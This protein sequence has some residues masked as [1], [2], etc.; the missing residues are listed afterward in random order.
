MIL[1]PYQCEALR[2]VERD[3]KT[4]KS[5]CIVQATGTGKTL[6]FCWYVAKVR[7]ERR[8]LI[9]V[10][11]S[12]LIS[13]T[14]ATLEA[15]GETPDIEQGER[16]V[17]PSLFGGSRIVVGTVQS[18][19]RPNR[20]SRFDPQEFGTVI[21]DECHR[22][23]PSNEQYRVI[24]EHFDRN[25]DVRHLGATATPM[26]GDG[27]ALSTWFE[28]ESYR[29]DLG[30]ATDEGWLVPFVQRYVVVSGI[31]W[32]SLKVV[33]GEYTEA[34]LENAMRDEQTHY[35]IAGAVRDQHEGRPTIAFVSGVHAAE[36]VA[37]ILRGELGISAESVNGSTPRDRRKLIYDGFDRGDV[38]VLVG[39]DVFCLDESTEILTSAGW[40]GIDEFTMNHQV[41]N[42]QDG[43]IWFSAVKGMVKRNR[44]PG[45]EIY[46]VEHSKRS[47][48]VTGKHRMLVRDSVK[49]RFEIQHAE[50]LAGRKVQVP[51]SGFAETFD[52]EP[53]PP[54]TLTARK[55]S[56]LIA[57]NAYNLRKS[58]MSYADAKAEAERR[59]SI[60]ES[61]IVKRPQELSLAEC[62]LI[63][64]FLAE[65]SKS[66]LASGGVEY[67]ISQAMC[68]PSIIEWFDAVVAE[69]GFDCARREYPLRSNHGVVLWSFCR[70]TG[71]GT[72][73][74]TGLFGIEPYLDK[75]GCQ[76]FWGLNGDQFAALIEGLHFGDGKHGK[77]NAVPKSFWITG[78]RKKLFDLLQGVACCRGYKASVRPV[79][80][81][82]NPNHSPQWNLGLTLCDAAWLYDNRLALESGWKPERVW[83]VTSESGNI[84]TRRNGIVT[85]TGNTEGFDSPRA[86]CLINAQVG[87]T[88]GRYI[89]K[90]GRV[91]RPL[92]GLLDSLRDAPV[93]DRLHAIAMSRKPNALVV[94]LNGAAEGL[95]LMSSASIWDG[96]FS[97]DAVKKAKAKSS[98]SGNAKPMRE[99]LK[100][101]ELELRAVA[102]RK[103][104]IDY[105]L[106]ASVRDGADYGGEGY[107]RQG[108]PPTE[109]QAS[110]LTKWGYMPE[111]MDRKQA[112]KVIDAERRKREC[113]P[114]SEAQAR[115]IARAG[116]STNNGS[117]SLT[118]KEA[119]LILDLREAVEF[120]REELHAAIRSLASLEYTVRF[121]G[122]ETMLE[123]ETM[124]GEVRTTKP[125]KR[126]PG[127]YAVTAKSIREFYGFEIE[128][129]A[130]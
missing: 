38:R 23:V 28:K 74:R 54:K 105:E 21:W 34:S 14:V 96:E 129:A 103:R 121:Q 118:K 115:V 68:Y 75:E 127:D 87:K 56:R 43:R 67:T 19:S 59:Q 12:E 11:R 97:A 5:V 71:G 26:R 63:G 107:K 49:K 60:R 82:G 126:K 125:A 61:M 1:R 18:I 88:V 112:S 50:K 100:E 91:A 102:E 81:R 86:A 16:W 29:F 48:R 25:P 36:R 89:Q 20:L 85:V 35:E 79:T 9:V 119:S 53:P 83:C 32:G 109:G 99:L 95:D 77:T 80:D 113:E 2:C 92:K 65:G 78:T 98:E 31:D 64:F 90:A 52:W 42:W 130:A 10:H 55:R 44:L 124:D 110:L 3:H 24:R 114:C 73:E 116:L 39:C 51:V 111:L 69:S 66:K 58:G 27:T 8:A 117:R 4:H 40:V 17:A 37:E 101:A 120:K 122:Y 70:G 93:K 62:K 76:G 30:R 6:T 13:Q 104:L 33:K 7:T 47:I 57:A 108:E 45:E 94:D 15:L 41:A 84:V 22:A 72:Q 106:V 123:I 46:S 128:E